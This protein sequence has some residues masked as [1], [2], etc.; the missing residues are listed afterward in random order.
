MPLLALTAPPTWN[1]DGDGLVRGAPVVEE[2]ELES[3]VFSRETVGGNGV[4]LM[5]DRL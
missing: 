4:L 1:E 3:G 2:V 5:R